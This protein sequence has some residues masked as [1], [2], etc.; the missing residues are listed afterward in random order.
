MKIFFKKISM[1]KLRH[2]LRFSRAAITLP[3]LIIIICMTTRSY[4]NGWEHGAIPYEALV[5][6]LEFESPDMRLRA[7]QSLGI[8]GQTEAV[9]PLLKCLAKPEEKPF[10]RSAVY[11]ALG[12]L[13]DRRGIPVLTACLD[14]EMREELRSDCVTALGMIGDDGTLTQLLTALKEDSAFLVQSSVVDALGGFSEELAV[15]TLAALVTEDG[16]RHL[17]QRAIRALGKTG[18]QAAVKPLLKALSVSRSDNE[19]LLIVRALTD[20][21]SAEASASLTKLLH[22]TENPQ[23]RTQIVIA[24]G[25]I[26]DGDVYPILMAMLTDKVPAVRYFAVKSLHDQGRPEAAMSISRLSLEISGRLAKRSTQELLA[27]PVPVIADL[28]FQ[29]VALQ[30]ITDLD[31][32]KGLPALLHAARPRPIPLDSALALKIAEGF[33]RQRR[34]ALNGLGYTR[35]REAAAFL[36]GQDGIGDPD[37]RLRAVAVRS[38][39]VLSFSDASEKVIVCLND[40]VAEVRWTAAAILGR[41]KDHKAV[42]PLMAQLSDVNSEVRRQAVLSLGYLGDRLAYDK[43]SR[44][45]ADDGSE[46]V[47]AAAAYSLQLLA[48]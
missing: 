45:A 38:L 39:G 36:A 46:T 26:R 9:E 25:T 15:Q 6:A 31:A 18:S 7:A 1:P 37:F 10:V 16:N 4:G 20:L 17:R 12:K 35:S 11:I 22:K 47:R 24:L 19:R 14:E 2:K 23:L 32:Y 30:A 27:D 33:Y 29:V 8:R 28:S 43:V 48:K 13:G 41:L 42:G 44:L 3:L 40:P 21:R 5:K 34:V